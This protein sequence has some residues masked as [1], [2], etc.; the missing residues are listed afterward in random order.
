MACNCCNSPDRFLTSR[1]VTRRTFLGRGA[2]GIGLLGLNAL[3]NPRLFA[4]EIT[5]SKGVVNPLHHPAKAK[6]VIFLYQA[7]GPSHL[8]TFDYKPKLA[9]MNGQPMPESLTKGQQI[10]QLQ[11]KELKCFAPQYG[12]RKFGKSGQEICE[13]FPHIGSVADDI[14][15]VRSMW[16]EQINHDP[17]HTIMN[18]GSI[19]PGRPSM[20]SW[21]FYGL[22]SE[23][24]DL[25]GFVVLLSS[26]RGGQMQPIAARQWSSGLLPSKY[27]G[28]KLNSIGD[29]V[30]YI[31]NPRGLNAK[32]QRES[33]DAINRLNRLEDAAVH[34]PEIQTRISQYEMA[35]KMQTSVP[36]LMDMSKEPQSVL[37]AYGAHPGDGSFASNCLLARRLAE[38]GVRFIQ[39]YHRDWDHHAA[40]KPNVAL[41]AEEVD[42]PTAALIT[43]LK[44]R[45]ML[46]DTLIVWGGEFGRTPMSQ[47]GD[48]RDHHIKGFSFMMA[49]GG[50]KPGITFG[51]TDEFGYAAEENPVSIHDFHATMLHL[52]GVDH[53]RLTLKF[54]GQ[55]V[56]LTGVTGDVV[57]GIL[58]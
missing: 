31:E 20:G 28:V 25:P 34:D 30:L 33:I 21:I 11:G 3:L 2:A 14:C 7:G 50:I 37:E 17:A 18:T 53:K 44:Q 4:A 52:L 36:G 46:E 8:E 5:T 23:A 49:G 24:E 43:D 39:L 55:D 45:G 48:G 32:L 42:K 29:P 58:A 57:K 10:A 38:R 41:K 1:E 26:G 22:G 35:F 47:S 27:Q 9:A 6:R 51:S 12:F 15:I 19:I 40:L 16:T 54:Q 56:R 13:L